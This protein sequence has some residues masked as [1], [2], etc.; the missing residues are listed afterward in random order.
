DGIRDRNVTGVQTCALPISF[1]YPRLEQG[2]PTVCAET[3]VGRLRYIGLVLYDA[4]KVTEAASVTDEK[5]LYRSQM[6]VLL[7]P[8]DPEVIRGAEEAGIPHDWI[9]AAQ[10]SPTY[11]LIKEY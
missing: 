8:H 9:L 10:N 5:D 4:D 2:E 6:D 7:D 11:K 3:C 1:C